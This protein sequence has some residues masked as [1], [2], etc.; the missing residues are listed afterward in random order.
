[1]HGDDIDVTCS[2]RNGNEHF[3]IKP[4]FLRVIRS[5]FTTIKQINYTDE[6]SRIHCV[7]KSNLFDTIYKPNIIKLL[8]SEHQCL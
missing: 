6:H 5:S 1:M 7:S 2:L 3:T 4:P 8:F